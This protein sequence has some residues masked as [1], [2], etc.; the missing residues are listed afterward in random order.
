MTAIDFSRVI[1][2][3]D[4][5]DAENRKHAQL[6]REEARRR[7]LE[8]LPFEEQLNM[9]RALSVAAL[10]AVIDESETKV[11][12]LTPLAG[13]ELKSILGA[14]DWIDQMR[15]TCHE[16]IKQGASRD[17]LTQDWPPLPTEITRLKR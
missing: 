8:A 12:G 16:K 4:K 15:D 2:S 1:T 9:V 14:C 13:D 10:R 5:Q 11:A 7:I 3:D 6:V 17:V